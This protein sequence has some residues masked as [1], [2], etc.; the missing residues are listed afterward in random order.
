[1]ARWA[2]K[3]Q[4]KAAKIAIKQTNLPIAEKSPVHCV[5]SDKILHDSWNILATLF[6]GFYALPAILKAEKV[7]EARLPLSHVVRASPKRMTVMAWEEAVQ[8]LSKTSERLTMYSF[9]C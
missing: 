7:L 2:K 9:V 1:M 6:R 5:S 3:A 8:E 4:D